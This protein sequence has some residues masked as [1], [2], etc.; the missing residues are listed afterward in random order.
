MKEQ[1]KAIEFAGD[2]PCIVLYDSNRNVASAISY[3]HS[4]ASLGGLG[5]VLFGTSE[6]TRANLGS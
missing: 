2:N 6:L 3:W 1:M 5:G 4:S